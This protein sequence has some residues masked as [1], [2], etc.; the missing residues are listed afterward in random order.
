MAA[1]WCVGEALIDLVADAPG[2]LRH[3]RAFRPAPGGAPA[4]VAVGVARLGGPARFLGK[5][6]DDEFG[7]LIRETLAAAG[8]DVSNLRMTAEARTGLAFVSLREDGERDFLF[9]RSPAADMLLRPEDLDLSALAD[10]D[11]LC[12]GTVALAAQPSRDT[13]LGLL[14][15]AR[16][17][18]VTLVCDPNLRLSLWPEPEAALRTARE[19]LAMAHVAKLSLEEA[20]LLTGTSGPDA[21][22]AWL[23]DQGV[24]LAVV[25][26]GPEGAYFATR[27]G[28]R[29][30]VPGFP[31]RAVDTTGAGDGFLAGLLVQLWQRQREGI[32][33]DRLTAADLTAAV[34]FAN[35]VGALVV[36]APGAITALP[37]R[38]AVESFLTRVGS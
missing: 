12:Y 32:D 38:A 24:R 20:E 19:V 36:T 1:I 5:V 27:G 28:H 9:Y 18:G 13:I 14:E 35:A 23:L 22:A 4:N 34:R 30:R 31:V 25:T 29:A 37:D 26:L 33:L 6:G 2:P 17:R 8:V 11:I 3:A 10:G 15:T 16:V 7:H 21:A